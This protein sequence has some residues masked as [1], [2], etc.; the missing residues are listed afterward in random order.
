MRHTIKLARAGSRTLVNCS[1]GEWI[2]LFQP[3]EGQAI[4]AAHKAHKEAVGG[5]SQDPLQG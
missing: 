1:C 2:G 3:G 5:P 4:I